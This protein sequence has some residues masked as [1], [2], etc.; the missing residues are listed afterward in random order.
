M[1]GADDL[2]RWGC[3]P[4]HRGQR[5]H[6]IFR[7]FDGVWRKARQPAAAS[8]RGSTKAARRASAGAE[9]TSFGPLDPGG[10]RPAER[11]E[12]NQSDATIGVAQADHPLQAA[13]QAGEMVDA[14]M[15]EFWQRN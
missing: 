1:L 12:A 11:S 3:G 7:D 4:S 15:T 5:K 10:V 8:E 14:G 13:I 6:L 2:F 9:E